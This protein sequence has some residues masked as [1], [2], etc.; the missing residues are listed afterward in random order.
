VLLFLQTGG[1]FETGAL[2]TSSF[3][4]FHGGQTTALNTENAASSWKS[5][6][7]SNKKMLTA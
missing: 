3:A 5:R 6:I 2:P 7:P 1:L 4:N